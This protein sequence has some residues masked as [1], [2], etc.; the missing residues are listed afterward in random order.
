MECKKDTG[1]QTE[2]DRFDEDKK[3]SNPHSVR[4]TFWTGWFLSICAGIVVELQKPFRLYAVR[5]NLYAGQVN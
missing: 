2:L 1:T 4:D 3:A 5:V